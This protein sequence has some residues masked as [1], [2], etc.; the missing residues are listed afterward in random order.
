MPGRFAL[1][2]SA[3]ELARI[4]GPLPE[5]RPAR[6]LGPG[7]QA[8]IVHRHLG[9]GE[10][11]LDLLV[12]GLVPS[13]TR[14]LEAMQKPMEVRSEMAADSGM[15]RDALTSRRCLVPANSF[16]EWPTGAERDQPFAVAR[17]DREPLALAAVW[18][19]WQS[20]DGQIL[21][22]FAIMTTSANRE[23]SALHDRMPVVIERDSWS[24]W[25]GEDDGDVLTLLRPAPDGILR[26]RRSPAGSTLE[27]DN[28]TSRIVAVVEDAG[29]TSPA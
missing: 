25:L 4:S 2:L 6:D 24:R 21:R 12:W 9:S 16:Q 14:D 20:P 10:R 7:Q 1:D 11:R 17:A 28:D 15:L 29:E 27:Q 5:V 3:E 23:M 18:E 26:L 8:A 19:R 22:T 13:W